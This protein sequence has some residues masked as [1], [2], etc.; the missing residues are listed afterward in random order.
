[1]KY[2]KIDDIFVQNM[3]VFIYVGLKN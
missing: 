1:V 2:F 3:Q